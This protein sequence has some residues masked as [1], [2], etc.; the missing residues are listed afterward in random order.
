MPDFIVAI[1]IATSHNHR[2]GE[3]RRSAGAQT[4]DQQKRRTV[5]QKA[6]RLPAQ[7]SAFT[8]CGLRQPGISDTNSRLARVDTPASAVS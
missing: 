4:S 5:S 2:L 8:L 7:T 6:S 1:E 3:T